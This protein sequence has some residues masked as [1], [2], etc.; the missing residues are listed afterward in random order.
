LD[1]SIPYFQAISACLLQKTIAIS[2]T[3]LG[4]LKEDISDL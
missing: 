1:T 4:A 2:I 3:S